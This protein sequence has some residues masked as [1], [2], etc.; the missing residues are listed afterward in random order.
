MIEAAIPGDP[1]PEAWPVFAVLLPHAQA[2]WPVQRRNGPDCRLPGS[3]RQLRLPPV[4]CQDREHIR[5]TSASGP[6]HPQTL[7][8]RA[9]LARWTGEAGDAAGARDQFAALLPSM[10]GS[11]APITRTPWPSAPTSPAGPGRRAMRPR[12][13]TS[14][15]RCCPSSERVLGPEHPDTLTTRA[16]LARWTGQAGDAAG[17]RDQYA[18]LLPIVERVFGPEHP[19]TLTDRA[20]LARWTGEAGDAAGARDQYAALL[21]IRERVSAPSTRHPERP[22]Q[23]RPLD[24]GGG[25]SGRGPR[26]VR[27]AAAHPRAGPRPRAPGHPES[28]APTSPAGPSRREVNLQRRTP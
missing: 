16:N 26:P 1:L 20:N 2:A 11:W 22:R 18:A 6:E 17:A 8:A 15:P 12:P 19:D 7:A 13:A 3:Q 4:I 27:R 25:R 23:P 14:S 5:R 28:P 9:S 24:G 21:P 10:S